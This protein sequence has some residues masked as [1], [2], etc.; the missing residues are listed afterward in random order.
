[1]DESALGFYHEP[2]LLNEVTEYLLENRDKTESKVYVDCTLGGGGYTKKILEST[3][4]D[5]KVIAIDRDIHAL[6]Y[7]KKTLD[8]YNNRIIYDQG[9]FGNIAEILS[10]N[11][12][13]K[14]SG[15]VMDLGLSSYQLRSEEGFSYQTDT[16]LDMRADKSQKFTAKDVL[17]T[18]DEKE[19]SRLLEKYGELRYNRK[20]ARD[21]AAQR[22]IKKFETTFD[23]V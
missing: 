6:E 19:L 16:Q 23:L 5:T 12:Y 2:V 14:I 8:D 11:G 10:E 9:N 15:I 22:K 21:I 17:N 18:Y 4:Q 20:V 1:M 13:E 7:C 3:H